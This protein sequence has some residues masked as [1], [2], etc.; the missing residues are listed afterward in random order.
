M[1]GIGGFE[2]LIICLFAFLVFGPEQMPKIAR[3]VGRAIQKFRNARDE[4]NRIL[5]EEVYDPSNDADD[6]DLFAG[7]FDEPDH[8][9]G[10]EDAER[11]E[12]GKVDSGK[13]GR[14]V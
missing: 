12:K 3:T 6:G 10:K 9:S 8:A 14:D 13:E 11:S 2:F 5:N 1:F 7:I 4:M